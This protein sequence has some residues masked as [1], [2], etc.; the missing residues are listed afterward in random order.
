MLRPYQLEMIE[1]LRWQMQRH[2][3]VLG[4]LPTGG[5]KTRIF[6]EIA[7]MA[8]EKGHSVKVLVHRR[9]LVEQ[10]ADPSVQTIQSWTPQGEDL[11]IVDEAHHACARTW[12]E[13][14]VACP[15]VLGF[16]A[17]PQRL[18]GGGL[19]VIFDEMVLGPDSAQLIKE[20]WLSKYRLFAPPGQP[21]LKGIRKQAGDYSRKQLGEVCK[22]PKVIAAAL[23]NWRL[24]GGSRQTIGFCVSVAHMEQVAESFRSA[25]VSTVTVEGKMP[26]TLR[27]QNIEAFR[28][29]VAQ[30]LLSVDL[31]SEGFDVPEC[32]CV[33]LLRPTQSLG[34]YLQQVGRGLRPSE[35]HTVIL[36]CA[37]N[38]SRHGMPDDGRVWALTGQKKTR[39]GLVANLP[40]RVCQQC[41]SVH[42]VHLRICP[43]CGMAH[44]LSDQIPEER[45]ILLEERLSQQKERRRAVG[46]ART[47]EQLESIALARGYKSGWVEAILRS[48]Q[49][50]RY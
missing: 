24:L 16:T 27:D 25:G 33:L 21:G 38:S 40:V 23:K 4:V 28:L 44:P 34:L 49:V 39:E 35:K 14:L 22:E 48:R 30:V 17:T 11:V 42:K 18:D 47:R 26:K 45:D 12:H 2:Q 7:R 37:G 20:G 9:E 10:T 19:D 8:R 6:C 41:Y 15:R 46:Q 36:D 1:Q 50:R 3:K 43:Y 31:I 13:K 32:S 29:G 5:G